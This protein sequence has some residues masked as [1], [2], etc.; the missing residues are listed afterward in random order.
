[1]NKKILIPIIIVILVGG[2]ILAWHQF[3]RPAEELPA[4]E[5]PVVEPP[6]IEPPVIE[7]PIVEPPVVE[8]PVVEPPV[9]VP[10]ETIAAEICRRI[11]TRVQLI[12]I[13][14]DETMRG[15]PL[16]DI[17]NG[18]EFVFVEGEEDDPVFGIIGICAIFP[19]GSPENMDEALPIVLMELLPAAGVIFFPLDIT[20]EAAVEDMKADFPPGVE[21]KEI[22]NI[23]DRAVS[24]SIE[25]MEMRMH[26]IIFLDPDVNQ[27]MGIMGMNISYEASVELAR[28]VERNLR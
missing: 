22:E 19:P 7:P 27:V 21:M 13:M 6:V 9:F 11:I 25:E 2:G 23:G 17:V 24:A 4:V 8:P 26:Q 10:D 5:P 1:M 28:Q 15:V 18:E 20:F 14:G 3:I 12:E 16:R